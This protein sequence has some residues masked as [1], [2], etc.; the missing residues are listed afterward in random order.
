[1]DYQ[2]LKVEADG[3]AGIV[4]LHRPDK[5]NAVSFDLVREI[6]AAISEMEQNESVR[7]VVITG[8]E[9]AFSTGADL[10]EAVTVDTSVKFMSY[11]RLWRTATYAMEHSA[12]PI[13]AAVDGYCLTGGLELAMACDIRIASPRARFGI[14]SSKIGSVAGAGGTQRLPRLVGPAVAMDLLFSARHIDASEAARIG[15]VNR[16]VDGNVVAEAKAMVDVFAERGPLS[17]AWM[18]LAVHTGMNTDIESALDLE[19]VISGMAFG[20]NDKAE[21]M[22]AFLEKRDPRFTGS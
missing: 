19:A 5:L 15:L 18:K 22:T 4:T 12:K 11:N 16:V 17:I 2:N 8:S 1:V 3:T 10:S 6:P 14:T 13:I 9:R 21:G 7:G 20:S